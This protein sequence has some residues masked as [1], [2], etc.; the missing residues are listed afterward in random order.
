MMDKNKSITAN[1]KAITY[2]LSAR[3]T[4]GSVSLSP[5]GGSYLAG[6]QVTLTA[7]PNSGYFFVDWS[8]DLSGS[9]NPVKITVD[10]NKNIT[11][12]FKRITYTLTANAVNGSIL[13]EPGGGTYNSGAFVF[14]TALPDSG[15]VFNGWSGSLT[16]EQNPALL[17]MNQNKN[18]TALFKQLINTSTTIDMIPEQTTLGQIYP[19]PFSTVTTIPFEIK[20]TS[21]IKIS[22]INLSGQEVCT[23]INKPLSPGKYTIHW[24]GSDKSGTRVT[25]GIYFCRMESDSHSVQVR[26][27]V[28]RGL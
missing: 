2:T 14:V 1:F 13:M 23:L 5:V 4:N 11:A 27:I 22:I 8:G 16:G 10:A 3:G 20:E 18:I 9:E 28:F 6:S 26:K 17:T 12:N 21:H 24:N 7:K 25:E 15:Y 19:N